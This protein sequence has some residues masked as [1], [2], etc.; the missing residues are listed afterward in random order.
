[1]N[2]QMTKTPMPSQEPD[3]RNKN[4]KEVALGYTEEMAVNEAQRC[5]NCKNKPCVTGCPV[6]VRIPEF[7]AKVA[8]GILP[9]P[10]K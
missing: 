6:N 8:E 1:M 3:V 9:V 7:I 2:N 4:F 10:M 5:L